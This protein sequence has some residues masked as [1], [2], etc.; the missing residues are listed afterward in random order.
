MTTHCYRRT[1]S[2]WQRHA[3]M[4]DAP[5]FRP[6]SW[7]F[8]SEYIVTVGL[9]IV[10]AECFLRALSRVVLQASRNLQNKGSCTP[11]NLRNT[12]IRWSLVTAPHQ[13][14]IHFEACVNCRPALYVFWARFKT[15]SFLFIHAHFVVS[16]FC[17]LLCICQHLCGS[18]YVC[19]D[20]IYMY[21]YICIKTYE[22]KDSNTNNTK[23]TSKTTHKTYNTPQTKQ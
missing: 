2:S 23:P 6:A 1:D 12:Q 4:W 9:L 5:V 21:I 20:H 22:E 10:P 19:V 3:R 7:T 18:L 16:Y 17:G 13:K 14:R 15:Q 11:W 8:C